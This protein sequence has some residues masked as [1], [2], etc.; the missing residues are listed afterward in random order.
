MTVEPLY[1][2]TA[3]A[4][5]ARPASLFLQKLLF[6]LHFFGWLFLIGFVG[7]FILA[8]LAMAGIGSLREHFEVTTPFMA[9]MSSA[10][11][12]V[13][14]FVFL[15]IIGQL[16]AI[17]RTLLEGDPF[18][19]QNADRLRTIWIAVAGGEILRLVSSYFISW[20][21]GKQAGGSGQELEWAPDLRIYV[22]FMVLALIILSAVFREGARLRQ[23][24]KLTV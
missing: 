22:W 7:V 16:R 4:P 9:L 11:M 15:I 3:D 13:G 14:T 2:N 21:G 23:E 19:P 6:V 12:I 18:V 5:V 10:S 24:Q 1:E 20:M 17:C 8:A